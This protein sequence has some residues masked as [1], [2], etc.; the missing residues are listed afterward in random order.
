MKPEQPRTIFLILAA[1]I[2]VCGGS[3]ATAVFLYNQLQVQTAAAPGS[4]SATQRSSEQ[5][6]LVTGVMPD[7][8]AMRANLRRGDILLQAGA[9]TLES[10]RDLQELVLTLAAGE[11]IMLTV[12]RGEETTV[13]PITPADAPPR[14]GMELLDP[15]LRAEFITDMP[16]ARND[17]RPTISR[18][19]PDTPAS[20]AELAAGDVIAVINDQVIFTTADLIAAL[21][22]KRPGDVVTLLLRRGPD[23]ISRTLKL[24][25]YPDD[26]TRGY[27]GVELGN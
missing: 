15:G 24:G 9:T 22:D 8:A 10:T 23:T 5:G 3:M 1:V 21:A 16:A 12:L 6:L 27:L 13:I 2:L 25:T 14:L 19:L 11:P 26:A 18:V 4:L 17:G 7:S 20:A